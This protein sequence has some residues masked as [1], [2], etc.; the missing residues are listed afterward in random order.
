MKKI[1][2]V[3]IVIVV[4]AGGLGGYFIFKKPVVAP[5][6]KCGDNICDA[7]E[8]ENLNACPQDCAVLPPSSSSTKTDS[9]CDLNKDGKVD[10][11]EE[12]KCQQKSSAQPLPES[13]SSKSSP[14]SAASSSKTSKSTA[15]VTVDASQSL[16]KFSPYLFGYAGSPKTMTDESIKLARS[17]GYKLALVSTKIGDGANCDNSLITAADA[18]IDA[19]LKAGIEPMPLFDPL[20][21]PSNLDAYAACVK[22]T[23]KHLFDKGVKIFRFTNEPDGSWTDWGR[24]K[25]E[26]SNPVDVAQ[27]YEA[28]AKALKSVDKSIIIEGPAIMIITENGLIADWVKKF[29]NY[30]SEHNAPLDIFSFHIYSASPYRYYREFNVVKNELQKYK[31]SPLYGVPKLGN[32]EWLMKLG[33]LWSGVYSEEFDKTWAASAQLNG[34]VNMIEEG[35]VLSVPTFGIDIEQDVLCHDFLLIN[36]RGK[37][38]PVFYAFQAFNQLAETNRLKISGTDK[39]N[40][41]AISGIKEVNGDK[42][43][44]VIL[45]NH[46]V[47]SYS[48]TYPAPVLNNMVAA[49]ADVSSGDVKNAQVYKKFELK[50]NNV[51]WKNSQI[52]TVKRYLIDDNNALVLSEKNGQSITVANDGSV[53]LSA[54]ISAPQVQII[55]LSLK[56]SPSLF[57]MNPVLAADENYG[58]PDVLGKQMFEKTRSKTMQ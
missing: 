23:G 43:I 50:I 15:S 47:S 7:V 51:P 17:A 26:Q 2:L 16:G 9:E 6:G 56:D 57:S 54:E 19:L 37:A 8:K 53:S 1:I 12:E 25:G 46:D 39:M 20:K 31:I 52:I 48:N 11:F 33:D 36:C 41:A 10:S 27:T 22:K 49:N 34:L 29:L 35:A 30:L 4:V 28:W 3:I 5:V 58:K 44:I 24:K 42:Q 38:K 40:F 14:I 18:Q 55:T 21:K 32:D 45:S 13:S